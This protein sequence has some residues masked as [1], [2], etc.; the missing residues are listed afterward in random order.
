MVH[1]LW[2]VGLLWALAEPLFAYT[3][4]YA[5][6]RLTGIKKNNV[7]YILIPMYL[8]MMIVEQAVLAMISG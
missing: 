2:V 7:V 8:I 1:S 5:S 4:C 6:F 3:L